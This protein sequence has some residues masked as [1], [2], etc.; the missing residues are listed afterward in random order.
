MTEQ[1][2]GP[3]AFTTIIGPIALD[4]AE[5]ALAKVVMSYVARVAVAKI[6]RSPKTVTTVKTEGRTMLIELAQHVYGITLEQATAVIDDAVV[7]A[8]RM[9]LKAV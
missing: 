4:Q 8:R 7:D 6:M 5:K 9:L 2:Q 3:D 1:S